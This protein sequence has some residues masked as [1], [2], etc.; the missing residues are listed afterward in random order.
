MLVVGAQKSKLGTGHQHEALLTTGECGKG[1]ALELPLV[2]FNPAVFLLLLIIIGGRVAVGG[3]VGIILSVPGRPR[4]GDGN[5]SHELGT[6]TGEELV[7]G[8]GT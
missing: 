8:T 5:R 1:T 4:R 7:V 3:K 6:R 2:V